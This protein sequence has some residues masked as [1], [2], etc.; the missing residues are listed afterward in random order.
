MRREFSPAVRAAALLRAKDRCQQC[1]TKDSL[2]LH[3]IGHW[4]DRSLFNC[5]VLCRHCHRR[6]HA[7]RRR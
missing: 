6:V 1:G 4:A 2:E 7:L 5:R 3:H